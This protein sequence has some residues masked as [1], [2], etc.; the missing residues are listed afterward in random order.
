[1]LLL[2]VGYD[3]S[4]ATRT[5]FESE[6]AAAGISASILWTASKLEMMLYAEHPDLLFGYFGI[7]LTK[8]AQTKEGSL[9]RGLT[10]NRKLT[11]LLPP[12]CGH[13]NIIINPL[14]MKSTRRRRGLE[15][16][17]GAW[18]KT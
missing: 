11:K 18:F 2:V 10:L 13:P 9:K 16:R 17:I 15:G 5:A 6:A 4:H 1:M 12:K 7:F 3:V 14:M 8:Q